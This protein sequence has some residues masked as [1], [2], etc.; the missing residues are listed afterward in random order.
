MIFLLFGIGRRAPSFLSCEQTLNSSTP[1]LMPLSP[2]III[3]FLLLL[4]APPPCIRAQ[5]SPATLISCNI[6]C[7]T[8]AL[9]HPDDVT[10]CSV[11]SIPPPTA[12]PLPAAATSAT[13]SLLAAARAA[14]AR[15][16]QRDPDPHGI[17]LALK[18]IHAQ[19]L[20]PSSSASSP[21]PPAAAAAA[22]A[23]SANAT[24]L[25]PTPRTMQEAEVQFLLAAGVTKG[26]VMQD[27]PCR[28]SVWGV[29]PRFCRT[30]DA[31]QRTHIWFCLQPPHLSA[32]TNT[33]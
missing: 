31:L 18:H 8:E 3:P 5:T 33:L 32:I 7:M 15:L 30:R 17:F 16:R 11:C 22:A 26:Q 21:S 6:P 14:A 25:S 19:L 24:A 28:C 2:L 23:A 10:A 20:P 13:S 9:L 29:G 1:I 12:T 27:T 4:L